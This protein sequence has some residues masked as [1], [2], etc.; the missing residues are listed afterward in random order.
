MRRASVVRTLGIGLAWLLATGPAAHAALPWDIDTVVGGDLAGQPSLRL[1][2]LDR[3]RLSYKDPLGLSY[4]AWTG[5]AWTFQ[6]VDSGYAVGG[7]NALALDSGGLPRIA[8][9]DNTN[10]SNNSLKYASWTGTA[11]AVATVESGVNSG[12]FADLALD[13][14]GK[15]RISYWA[16]NNI[17]KYA[18]WT[19][20]AW[21][22]Q[23]VDTHNFRAT[24]L[25]LDSAGK[26]RISYSAGAVLGL[27]YAA[28]DGSAWTFQTVDKTSTVTGYES[29][30]ALDS[31]GRPHIS[32]YDFSNSR[33]RFAEW[34]GSTWSL[35]T[36]D[37]SATIG[38]YTSLAL[39][40]AGRPRIAYADLMGGD[41]RYAEWDG[42][43]WH[44][45][46]IAGGGGTYAFYPSLAIDSQGYSWIG[47]Y[48]V[49]EGQYGDLKLAHQVPEPATLALVALGAAAVLRRG[50]RR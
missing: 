42:A 11:W 2:G 24:S 34:T 50:R 36:V 40:A 28:W 44:I 7:Y 22:I 41:L 43:A 26:P 29:S 6:R 14:L 5:T 4:A 30:L 18:A 16:Y 8:Y 46:T 3:P 39:D 31:A 48:A 12:R 1:D 35:Q 49:S 9:C 47:Y 19:G 45:E 21:N 23:T 13:S 25:V 17:L 37:A 32:Y 38:S 27:K 20:T 10:T 33:L 15:P